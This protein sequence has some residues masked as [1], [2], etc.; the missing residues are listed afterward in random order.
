MRMTQMALDWE[1]RLTAEQVLDH[2]W[3]DECA[4]QCDSMKALDSTVV[5]HLQA[6][7]KWNAVKKGLTFQ[8]AKH[9][10]SLTLEGDK[11][12]KGVASRLLKRRLTNRQSMRHPPPP[13]PPGAGWRLRTVVSVLICRFTIDTDGDEARE[14]SEQ[15]KK[16]ESDFGR[17]QPRCRWQAHRRRGCAPRR[18]AELDAWA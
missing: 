13:P 11:G 12:D 18:K 8:L 4:N 10:A 7:Q 15:S 9:L 14:L 5:T 2:P 3:F 16:C 1:T 17:I 6:F